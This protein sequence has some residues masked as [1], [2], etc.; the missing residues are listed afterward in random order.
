VARPR[1]G[2]LRRHLE[3]ALG[4]T[5]D[6]RDPASV[7]RPSGR[8]LRDE[9]QEVLE[10]L[11]S[12]AGRLTLIVGAGASM[13]AELPSWPTLIRRVLERVAERYPNEIRDAWQR[14]IES[15]GLLAAGAVAKALT[16]S[17]ED[18][19]NLLRFALY[20]TRNP[21]SYVPQ[22]LAQQVAW[23]KRELGSTVVVATG[24][25]DGLIEEALREL[26]VETHSYVRW[27]EEP[28]DS[29]AVYHLHGRL[30]PSH[31]AT[32]RLVLSE[33]DYAQVQ[34]A[35]SWQ[36]RFMR[37][38][39]EN[40]TCLFVGLSMSDP[41]LIRWLYRYSGAHQ[42][43]RHVALFVRQASSLA[44]SMLRDSLEASTRARWTQCGVEA[45]W[46]DFFGET[47]QFL[48]ELTLRRANRKIQ[49]FHERAA[50]HRAAVSRYLRPRS[51]ARFR[52]QQDR[53]SDFLAT[54][55]REVRDVAAAGGVDLTVE[56]LGLGLWVADHQAGTLSCWVTADRRL[57]GN[58]A[59]VDNR[60]E[61]DSPWIAVEAVT[62]GVVVQQDPDVFASRWRL[63]R[64]VPIVLQE[65]DGAGR[66]VVG[67]MTLTSRTPHDESALTTTPRGLLGAIDDLLSD[68]VTQLFR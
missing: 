51:V 15:E 62:R 48:H 28:A 44:D 67:A 46:T 55:L 20:G 8:F 64:G 37:D 65:P 40:S 5:G 21:S 14:T 49:P 32:G 45:V 61:Y 1:I 38:A 10:R 59:L 63:V 4:L 29:A 35:G 22:A 18:F 56:D 6:L 19:R 17:D 27:R 43:G 11:A 23:M 13:E 54:L 60:L 50:A 66:V 57:N 12:D 25:Y 2:E 7:E 26:G 68:P 9:V 47:A 36:D 3:D 58:H 34:H 53:A 41:N 31:P 42:A 16:E 24:N 52:R 33:D 30:I 39:L